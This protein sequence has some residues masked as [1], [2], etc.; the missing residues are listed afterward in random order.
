MSGPIE[1]RI[2][3]KLT[4]AFQPV[5]LELENESHAHSV[6]KGSETHFRLAMASARF[7]GLTRIARQ[8]AVHEALKEEMSSGGVHALT[9]RL[10]TPMEWSEAGVIEVASPV[11]YGGS[12]SSRLNR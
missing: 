4:A 3:E 12:Q 7:E 2:R 1:T 6:P 9:Q 5:F 11:C 8:R 10:L